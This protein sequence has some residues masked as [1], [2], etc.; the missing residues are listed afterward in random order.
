MAEDRPNIVFILVDDLGKMDLGCEGSTFYETPNIDRL[1]A[2]SVR[3]VNGYSACQVCSPSRAAI[4]TGKYPPRVQITDYIAPSGANQPDQW[5]R[6]T[7]LLPAGF[8]KQLALEETTLAEALKAVG[9]STFFAGKWHLGGEGFYPEDQGY[10]IN[11]GGHEAGTPPGGYF[12]PYRNPKLSGP[13]GEY[14]PLRLGRET[15]DYIRRQADQTQPFF[16]MLSFYSVHAPIQTTEALW[17]KYRDKAERMGLVVQRQRFVFDRTQEVRQVQDNPLYAGMMEAMDA[18]V[19]LV[20]Q[21]VE[22]SG[23]AD[24]TV[25]VFTSDNGGVSSGD[26]YATS[27]LPLRGGKGRQWEGGIR[28]P[29]YIH[30]PGMEQGSDC[31]AF[32]SGIDFL[33]TL[34]EL[35]GGELPAGID[36]VSLVPALQGQPMPPRALYWHY[37]H[38]GNQGG[39]PSAIM[40]QGDWKL[41]HYYEDGRNELYNLSEDLGEQQD[42]AAEHPERTASMW[43]ALQAWLDAIDA[44]YPTPNPNFDPDAYARS[45]QQIQQVRMKNREREHW[46]YLQPDF[47]PR[48]GWWETRGR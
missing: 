41:I 38:Y 25:I 9:Y 46:G 8:R 24:N 37:P 39:E 6:N 20:L 12:A 34:V 15:A 30:L 48:G 13:P 2:R 35:A 47:V 16:A 32:A 4:Q 44:R 10:D 7:R 18:A 29:Y 11:V 40:R 31:E 17:R 27:A 28:Q 23:Q 3:F 1:A 14:L 33:P 19:G 43:R 45:L 36:G 5:R 26:G 42:V 22:Q 21:A